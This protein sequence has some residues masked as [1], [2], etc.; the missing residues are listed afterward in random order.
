[1]SL[2]VEGLSL[3]T[4]EAGAS[5]GLVVSERTA[6]GHD[7]LNALAILHLETSRALDREALSSSELLA[8]RAAVI[9]ALAINQGCILRATYSDALSIFLLEVSWAAGLATL[10]SFGE[11]RWA[12]GDDALISNESA[13]LTADDLGAFVGDQLV[14]VLAVDLGADA[15]SHLRSH[16]ATDLNTFSISESETVWAADSDA[17][18]ILE[19]ESLSASFSGANT[20]CIS[21]E[22]SPASRNTFVFVK[23]LTRLA[24]DCLAFSI[25]QS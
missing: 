15:I 6:L 19:L 23:F 4:L 17:L 10:L 8:L 9:D 18:A 1:M 21:L 7:D 2:L 12:T 16:G 24:V 20:I 5:A 14:A 13:V 3:S 22:S 11:S 25:D